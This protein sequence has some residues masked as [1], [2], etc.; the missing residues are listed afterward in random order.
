MAKEAKVMLLNNINWDF[1]STCPS[2][3]N[4]ISGDVY[5]KFPNGNTIKLGEYSFNIKYHH[6]DINIGDICQIGYE[7]NNG[8]CAHNYWFK[9]QYVCD[10]YHG[11]Y[12]DTEW[13]TD[14]F[15]SVTPYLDEINDLIISF[16]TQAIDI[17]ECGQLGKEAV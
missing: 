9:S 8:S 7:P 10:R 4:K 3:D 5:Y 17:A 6:L 12:R 13:V 11:G 16:I 1:M 2:A 14:M 15:K